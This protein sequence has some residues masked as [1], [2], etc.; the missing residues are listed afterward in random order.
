[1]HD[2]YFNESYGNLL[3]VLNPL[4]WNT[5]TQCTGFFFLLFLVNK[6]WTV[7][8]KDFLFFVSRLLPRILDGI[9]TTAMFWKKFES[10]FVVA[11]S[12]DSL[13]EFFRF[14]KIKKKWWWWK[15]VLF[16]KKNHFNDDIIKSNGV[17]VVVFINR[18][19]ILVLNRI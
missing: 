10:F 16:R 19:N 13:F 1:M 8:T 9:T 5:Q 4:S 14:Y 3:I 17:S 7:N 2:R 11:E 15:H 6:W 12:I 18:F